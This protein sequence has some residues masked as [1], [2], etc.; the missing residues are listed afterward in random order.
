MTP[1][2][3]KMGC[4]PKWRLN[5]LFD[6]QI[7]KPFSLFPAFGERLTYSLSRA[8]RVL[9]IHNPSLST[10]FPYRDPYRLTAPLPLFLV[11]CGL[12]CS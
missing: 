5:S 3:E 6:C 10:Q 8:L 7:T 11:N 9:S 1:E 2:A 4:V 12:A